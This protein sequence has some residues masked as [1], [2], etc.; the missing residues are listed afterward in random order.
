MLS[1]RNG[2]AN[3]LRAGAAVDGEVRR[4]TDLGVAEASGV[5]P[6]AF[7]LQMVAVWWLLLERSFYLAKNKK[8]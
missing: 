1:R 3:I 2:P 7:R 5:A 4:E 8:S 6:D